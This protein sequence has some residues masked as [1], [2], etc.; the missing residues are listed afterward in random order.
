MATP[1]R[2]EVRAVRERDLDLEQ[3][4]AVGG[5]WLRDVLQSKVTGAVE[6]KRSHGVKTTFSASRRRNSASPSA[7]RS[8]GR[9]TGSGTS[10]SWSI[11][12]A[13]GM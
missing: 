4:L 2:L 3:N 12:T 8:S 1:V 7:K 11:A 10:R 6:A 5:G 9:S 13:S